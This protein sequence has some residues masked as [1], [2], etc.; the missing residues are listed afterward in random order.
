MI[1]PANCLQNT[2]LLRHLDNI[3]VRDFLEKWQPEISWYA[4]MLPE[5]N[6]G[7]DEASIG[8]HAAGG[9]GNVSWELNEL[10]GYIQTNDRNSIVVFAQ[11]IDLNSVAIED[12]S[13]HENHIGFHALID[14]IARLIVVF[15]DLRAQS[16]PLPG[17]LKHNSKK[18]QD[19]VLRKDVQ[20]GLDILR[21]VGVGLLDLE[22]KNL[23]ILV[24]M[25][26]PQIDHAFGADVIG[27][28]NDILHAIAE[29]NK[30]NNAALV[31][32]SSNGPPHT[33]LR[34][35]NYSLDH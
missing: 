12:R 7:H 29:T 14:I 21:S 10:A 23:A 5:E 3:D 26:E 30:I 32:A 20:A 9:L 35:D 18:I 31:Q 11:P 24:D 1:R 28:L 34:Y 13:L 4:T 22:G 25:S 16:L 2:P 15:S 27:E 17:S 19:F 33:Y 6:S 8:R